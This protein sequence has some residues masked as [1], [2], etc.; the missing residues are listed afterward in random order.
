M[1]ITNS[2]K[3]QSIQEHDNDLHAGNKNVQKKSWNWWFVFVV[4]FYAENFWQ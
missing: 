4:S 1:Q 2:I 3:F